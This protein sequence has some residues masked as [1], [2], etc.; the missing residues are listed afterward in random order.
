MWTRRR[1][2]QRG[3]A[4]SDIQPNPLEGVPLFLERVCVVVVPVALPEAWLVGRRELDPA[5][6]LRALPEVLARD[7][8]PQRP[9][10]LGLQRLAVRVRR[11][12]R[13]LVAEKRERHVR[14]KA[15]LGARDRKA[16]A[17]L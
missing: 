6:P 5:Q 3:P 7:H 2:E 10:V 16:R 13:V 17:W 4:R 11:E 14:R 15:L 9:A 1:G 8:E 12:E